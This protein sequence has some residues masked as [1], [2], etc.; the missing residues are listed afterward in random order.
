MQFQSL[1]TPPEVAAWLRVPVRTL[2]LWRRRGEGPAFQRVGR[3]VR[4][5]SEDVEAYLL[6][7]R[8]HCSTPCRVA[9][10]RGSA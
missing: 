4:Y 10:S 6:A 8:T 1:M 3:A 2:E 5:S 9:G 7:R